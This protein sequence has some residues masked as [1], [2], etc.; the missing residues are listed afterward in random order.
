MNILDVMNW[1]TLKGFIGA[2]AGTVFVSQILKV[3]IAG[4]LKIKD[5]GDLPRTIKYCIPLLAA[6]LVAIS[7]QL[8]N[9][10]P[11]SG[12]PA[13]N[14][15]MLPGTCIIY[16]FASAWVY[17]YIKPM[18]NSATDRVLSIGRAG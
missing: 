11:E 2:L 1:D 12:V 14:W 16:G 9:Y 8:L 3:L 10:D 5:F 15:R 17:N 6:F 4:A 13:I 18:I 7:W